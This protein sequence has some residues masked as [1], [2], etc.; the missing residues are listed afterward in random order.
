M[1]ISIEDNG[2]GVNSEIKERIFEP[3][4]TTKPT[5]E[6]VGLGL[7][8]SNDIIAAHGGKIKYETS[9]PGNSRFIIALPV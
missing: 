9:G 2:M 4:F 3:F 8:I 5:G 7:S 1:R 6:G